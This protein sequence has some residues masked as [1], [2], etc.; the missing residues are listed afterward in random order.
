MVILER[1]VKERKNKMDTFEPSY[2]TY[3]KIINDIKLTGSGWKKYYNSVLQL[4]L[5]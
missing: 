4:S 2:E 5:F 1:Q 3:K